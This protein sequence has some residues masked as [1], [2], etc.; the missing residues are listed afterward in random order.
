MKAD[1]RFLTLAPLNPANLRVCFCLFDSVYLWHFDP[2][3]WKFDERASV[4]VW[5]HF[6]CRSVCTRLQ[7]WRL[8]ASCR[9]V[10]GHVMLMLRHVQVQRLL[11]ERP[12]K[13]YETGFSVLS[14]G[15]PLPWWWSQRQTE[16]LYGSAVPFSCKPS[17]CER[18]RKLL[19][20]QHKPWNKLDQ[21]TSN[22]VP[23]LFPAGSARGT[24]TR[25]CFSQCGTPPPSQGAE[26][27]SFV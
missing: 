8:E 7:F 23:S 10:T 2:L 19:S 25:G 20:A 6:L 21:V 4:H 14:S 3:T 12:C 22:T 11:L 27:E 26:A 18:L 5:K 24:F 15:R 9:R 17:P 16:H 13:L 1:T